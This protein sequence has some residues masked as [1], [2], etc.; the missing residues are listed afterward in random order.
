MELNVSTSLFLWFQAKEQVL[1]QSGIAT[2]KSHA[3]AANRE[4][5]DKAHW[6]YLMRWQHR[7]MKLL[8]TQACEDFY[9]NPS[10]DCSSASKS[11]LIIMHFSFLN[12][13]PSHIYL[14]L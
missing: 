9:Y 1:L 12:I 11:N 14:L 13:F 7:L 4:L 8:F 5:A 10:S 2:F 6:M 3:M